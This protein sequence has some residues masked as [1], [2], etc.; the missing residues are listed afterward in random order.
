[1][2]L[3][4]LRL[5]IIGIY[6]RSY[7]SP[8]ISNRQLQRR[9]RRPLV[10]PSAVIRIPDQHA[11][12][13]G[14]H[15]R[16]H[17][18]RHPIFHFRVCNADVSD[19][20]VS[21]DGGDEHEEHDYPTEFEAI[22]HDGDDD[23]QHGCN[24]VGDHRPELGFVGRIAEFHD[25][26]WEEETKGVQSGKNAEVGEGT[27]PGGDAEYAAGDFGPLERFMAVFARLCQSDGTEWSR[28]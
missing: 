5:V 11:R 9:S 18:K 6:E 7:E 27:K 23:C 20:C 3:V 10:M 28:G 25:D 4:V 8:A 1:M 16:G 21:D 26:G 19:D 17:Q 14:I 24:G 12:D 13:T 15:A 2:T 22:G